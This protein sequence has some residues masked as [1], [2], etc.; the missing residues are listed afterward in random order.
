MNIMKVNK[1]GGKDL[2]LVSI[3]IPVYNMECYLREALES[4]VNQ[5]YK[6]LEIIVVND[7]STDG[8]LKIIQEYEK[9][10]ER[11]K[12]INQ[13]NCGVSC[14][15]NS[16]LKEATGKYIYFFDSDDILELE[17]MKDCVE[18][19]EKDKLD[20]ILFDAVSFRDKDLTKKEKYPEKGQYILGNKV[21]ENKMYFGSYFL[22][23]DKFIPTV[24]LKFIKR[25]ILIK[26][27]LKFYE[28]IVHEDIL[29]SIFLLNYCRKVGYINKKFFKRRYRKNSIMTKE[30]GN[31]NIESY[32]IIAKELRNFNFDSSIKKIADKRIEAVIN[33]LISTSIEIG[34]KEY[35]SEVNNEFKQYLNWKS[36]LGIK[37]PILFKILKRIKNYNNY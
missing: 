31:L 27:N 26:N 15:R 19:A 36:K 1:R 32:L 25:D 17:A 3:I 7:G 2:E 4:V 22:L 16:G 21:K 37:C 20:L 12:V 5:L 18:K 13:N 23:E 11:I 35:F 14:A 34:N 9:K 8:S 24:W 10:D 30:R 33:N 6:K 29:F 28:G